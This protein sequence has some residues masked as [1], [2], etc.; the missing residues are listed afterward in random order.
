MFPIR[1]KFS[2]NILQSSPLLSAVSENGGSNSNNGGS[3]SENEQVR[4]KLAASK[5]RR[6]PV[7]KF[8]F[9]LV[10]VVLTLIVL[11]YFL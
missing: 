8:I 5:H 10:V 4:E 11:E 3:E 7:G 6:I 9:L 2:I 1:F